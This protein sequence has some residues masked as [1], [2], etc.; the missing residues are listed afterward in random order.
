MKSFLQGS[1]TATSCYLF[2]L[3]LLALPSAAA[4]RTLVVLTTQL[5]RASKLF[6]KRK[7]V[8]TFNDVKWMLT[9]T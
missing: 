2:S 7:I 6:K 5:L 3:C 1:D 9:I 4:L 8:E